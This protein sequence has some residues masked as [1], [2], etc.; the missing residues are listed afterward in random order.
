MPRGGGRASEDIEPFHR[1]SNRSVRCGRLRGAAACVG[2]ARVVRVCR[3]SV[4]CVCVGVG[5]CAPR[6]ASPLL[7]CRPWF[8]AQVQLAVRPLRA[9]PP[10]PRAWQ[11]RRCVAPLHAVYETN[12]LRDVAGLDTSWARRMRGGSFA[13]RVCACECA[14]ATASSP[15]AVS[16][17]APVNDE[18]RRR[19]GRRGASICLGGSSAGGG[20]SG[21]RFGC[22]PL[23]RCVTRRCW[24]PRRGGGAD[25][26]PRR[27]PGIIEASAGITGSQPVDAQRI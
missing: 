10:R 22:L 5:V 21:G 3:S 1:P 15:A 19:R 7:P 8:R 16:V 12:C 2:A 27:R 24:R 25:V 20:G 14:F 23:C 9:C 4:S 11:R 6:H 26:R 13:I 17:P 18:R